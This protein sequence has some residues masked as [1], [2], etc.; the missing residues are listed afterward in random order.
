MKCLCNRLSIE[1]EIGQV[2]L[3]F[4]S[5]VRTQIDKNQRDYILREQM[6]VIRKELGEDN[7][8]DDADEYLSKVEK[9]K[10]KRRQKKS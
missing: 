7:P 5:K 9:L 8:V 6:K 2:K 1:I 10:E 3:D 4:Q